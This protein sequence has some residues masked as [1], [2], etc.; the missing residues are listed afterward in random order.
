MTWYWFGCAV[1]MRAM[2]GRWVACDVICEERAR[3]AG[4]I[5][6]KW[7]P[8]RGLEM[9]NRGYRGFRTLC[10]SRIKLNNCLV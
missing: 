2:V 7:A 6:R 9:V 3:A 5:L 10:M 8:V 1:W 4:K